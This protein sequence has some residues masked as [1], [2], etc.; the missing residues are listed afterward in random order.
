MSVR[1]D[2][3]ES[4]EKSDDYSRRGSSSKSDLNLIKSP[5]MIQNQSCI[6]IS[7]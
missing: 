4:R 5:K 3:D 1:I 7:I 2:Q 6:M